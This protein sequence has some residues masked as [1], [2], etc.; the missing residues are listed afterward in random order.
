MVYLS[1]IQQYLALSLPRKL[2]GAD[3]SRHHYWPG[4][5]QRLLK[6]ILN[7]QEV[8]PVKNYQHLTTTSQFEK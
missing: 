6:L 7:H 4:P 5:H 8:V 2:T 1:A 3:A